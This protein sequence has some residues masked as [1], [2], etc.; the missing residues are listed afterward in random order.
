M[1]V[2]KKIQNVT[3]LEEILVCA[4]WI[5]QNIKNS[6]EADDY[7]TRLLRNTDPNPKVTDSKSAIGKY[8]AEYVRV[9][10]S[11]RVNFH[12]EAVARVRA[13]FDD[14]MVIKPDHIKA[15]A[16]N[17]IVHRLVLKP[18]KEY[19]ISKEEVFEEILRLTE[20]PPWN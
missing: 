3:N 7:L 4:N 16:K 9:G 8:L 13:F 20:M 5:T 11:P 14:S 12:L 10:A 19:K 6:P 2:G 17:V 1:V 15:V 18:G